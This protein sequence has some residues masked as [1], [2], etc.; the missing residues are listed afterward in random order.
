[1]TKKKAVIVIAVALVLCT[2]AVFAAACT[3]EMT[4]QEALAVLSGSSTGVAVADVTVTVTDSSNWVIYSYPGKADVPAE[5]Q[6]VISSFVPD[7]NGTS[8][9]DYNTANFT[10]LDL[11]AQEET[12]SLTGEITNLNAFLGTENLMYSGGTLTASI[13]TVNMRPL[14]VD[15]SY[16]YSGS[17][18]NFAIVINT[19]YNYQ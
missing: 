8:S 9:F 2:V 13:D 11:T 19:V 7:M 15:I 3:E 18:N 6:G 1:M 14:S 10:G 16:T 17:D 12:A 5:I 4:P